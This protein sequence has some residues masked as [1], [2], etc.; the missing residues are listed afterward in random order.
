MGGNEPNFS[1]KLHLR[2]SEIHRIK[3][4]TTFP[5]IVNPQIQETSN[6]IHFGNIVLLQLN[7]L[8]DQ[9]ISVDQIKAIAQLFRPSGP[10]LSNQEQYLFIKIQAVITRAYLYK[11]DF[12]EAIK[13]YT[14]LI[15]K[16]ITAES[17]ITVDHAILA[18]YTG[19]LYELGKPTQA[20]EILQTEIEFRTK[21]TGTR[22]HLTL[23]NAWL[24]QYLVRYRN[25]GTIDQTLLSEAQEK[26]KNYLESWDQ[27]FGQDPG[28]FIKYNK[29]LALAYI[30]MSRHIST[31]NKLEGTTMPDAVRA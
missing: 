24:I 12:K 18:N 28:R 27:R 3:Y 5:P 22:L 19:A 7:F 13:I 6:Y 9:N 16:H 21:N 26:Y 31:F 11:G 10:I 1:R 4:S 15:H 17:K 20:I 8:I 14:K 25:S 23:A 29:Y 2:L 30:A